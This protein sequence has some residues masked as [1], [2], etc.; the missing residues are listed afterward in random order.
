VRRDQLDA[1]DDVADSVGQLHSR[2]AEL[3]VEDLAEAAAVARA[4]E[5][6]DQADEL[7]TKLFCA[8]APAIRE[9]AAERVE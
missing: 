9:S 6:L 1:L 5:L 3:D 7:L 4:A 2:L 8:K